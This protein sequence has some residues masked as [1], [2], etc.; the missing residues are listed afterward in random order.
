M[1]Y[2]WT[3]KKVDLT[4][5]VHEVKR[6]FEERNFKVDLSYSNSSKKINVVIQDKGKFRRV[7]VEIS[8][9]PEDFS[10]EFCGGERARSIL[11]IG[12]LLALFGGPILLESYRTAEFYQKLEN[13][14]WN[15]LEK[16]VD[17]H[18]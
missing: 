18:A 4:L 13:Q 3:G 10:V 2:R 14:F 1:K 9:I 11:K 16:V 6:F 5:L 15:Y 12:S 8:G 17:K 7:S